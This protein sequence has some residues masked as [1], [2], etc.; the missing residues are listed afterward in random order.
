MIVRPQHKRCLSMSAL[1]VIYLQGTCTSA[2]TSLPVTF[3]SSGT[4]S[5][6]SATALYYRTV[7]E[8]ASHTTTTATENTAAVAAAAVLTDWTSADTTT[9]TTAAD[10]QGQGQQEVSRL[11]AWLQ[12]NS[13]SG[14]DVA[15]YHLQS[16]Q[17]ALKNK[18]LSLDEREDVLRAVHVASKG[19]T[20]VL[21]G[22]ARFVKG[23]L[24]NLEY[25][26]R[27]VLVAAAF[28]Y[29]GCVAVRSKYPDGLELVE[30]AERDA[31]LMSLADSSGIEEFGASVMKIALSAAKMKRVEVLASG[32]QGDMDKLRDLLVSVTEDW[33]ALA[34]RSY[35]CLFRLQGLEEQFDQHQ[36]QRSSTAGEDASDHVR[37][38]V[39]K[40]ALTVYACLSHRLGFYVLKSALEDTAFHILYP[41]QYEKVQQHIAAQRDG[42][43]AVFTSVTR[44]VKDSLQQDST[45]M[46]H[47]DSIQVT[48]RVKEPYSLWR[49]ILKKR[50]NQ[51][52]D[53]VA[54]RVILSAKKMSPDEDE[55]VT[56]ARDRALCYYVQEKC[57]RAYSP[58]DDESRLKDYIRTPKK[59]GYQ[60]LHYT[61]HMRWHGEN[62]PFEFQVRSA[63]MHRIAEH[64]VAAHWGYKHSEGS[65]NRTKRSPKVVETYKRMY[66]NHFTSL[67]TIK[68]N[69]FMCMSDMLSGEIN[70]KLVPYLEAMSEAH[71]DQT[72]DH[73]Y[74]FL[75]ENNHGENACQNKS[76]G[77]ILSLPAGACVVD[78]LGVRRLSMNDNDVL[79]NGE[80]CTTMT[81]RLH[82]GD[83]L[84]V[85]P[86]KTP[87]AFA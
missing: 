48:G 38:R 45:L 75:L 34:I 72:R 9:A 66:Q 47:V 82:N 64:G 1:A 79:R 32:T 23:I 60:S 33:R 57:M 28:H 46:S 58:T 81:Q 2:Y 44:Q 85:P 27:D 71:T 86:L 11:P 78:A 83:V 51:I 14:P 56:R 4:A 61:A 76:K 7:E 18:A 50:S 62:W 17:E 8:D 19:D 84:C 77:R 22:A 54:L 41:R 73:V 29:C 49:K 5:V 43:D 80:S 3:S 21:S 31:Y 35:A 15:Q 16:L 30:A 67:D 42:L 68:S 39:A 12:I 70:E 24:S 65:N 69:P 36:N 40:E 10:E 13:H 63:E 6:H 37:V 53:A 25:L 20:S 87:T 59:N 52:P 74:V 26:G 55:E